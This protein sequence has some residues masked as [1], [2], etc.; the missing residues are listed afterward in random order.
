MPDKPAETIT[1]EGQKKDPLCNFLSYK[2]RVNLHTKGTRPPWISKIDLVVE[3]TEFVHEILNFLLPVV[4]GDVT[5]TRTDSK[6]PLEM[7]TKESIAWSIGLVSKGEMPL[8]WCT[9]I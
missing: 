3:Y 7:Q 4:F 2:V 1:C 6:A 8:Q 5:T 9:I